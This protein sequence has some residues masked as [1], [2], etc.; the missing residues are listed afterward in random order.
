MQRLGVVFAH[1]TQPYQPSPKGSSGRP[2]HRPFRGLLG[3][4]PDARRSADMQGK[5]HRAHWQYMYATK[6]EREVTWF[7]DDAQAS[8]VLIEEFGSRSS[9]VIDIGGGTS[10]LGDDRHRDCWRTA[11]SLCSLRVPLAAAPMIL[12]LV[13]IFT[14]Q[15]PN[16]F[17]SINLMSYD[18]AGAHFG[19]PGYETDLLYIA[20]LV[21][22]SPSLLFA[23]TQTVSHRPGRTNHR[24][25]RRAAVGC[26]GPLKRARG[27]SSRKDYRAVSRHPSRC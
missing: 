26:A 10:R 4:S 16:G 5:N 11:N 18:A 14:V 8:L 25:S 23:G 3:V 7:Q 19:P 24:V 20:G 27:P 1:I 21:A 13:A 17:S 12:P 9:S 22:R 15:L 6:G 2:A